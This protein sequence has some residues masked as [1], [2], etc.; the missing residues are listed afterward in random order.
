VR[1][2]Y[3]APIRAEIERVFAASWQRFY[4]RGDAPAPAHVLATLERAA[5]R[6]RG[7]PC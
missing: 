1:A 7:V 3:L 6:E 4:G 2:P 5:D